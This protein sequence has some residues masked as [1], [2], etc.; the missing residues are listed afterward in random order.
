MK[1]PTRTRLPG[2]CLGSLIAALPPSACVLAD[3]DTHLRLNQSIEYRASQQERELLKDEVQPPSHLSTLT[4]DGQTYSVGDNLDDLGSALYLSIRHQQWPLVAHFLDAYVA[5]PGYDPMLAAYARGGLA[6]AAGDLGLAE[7][8]YRHLLALQD[9]FLPG[10]LELARVLFE[11]RKDRE[12]S[13]AFQHISARFDPSD[14]RAMG[15]SRSV[16]SFIEALD[17]REAWQGSIAI[18]PTWSDNLNLSSEDRQVFEFVTDEGILRLERKLPEAVSATGLD[19]EGTLNK[20]IALRGHHGLFIRSL[21][22]GQSY[23]DHKQYN[24]S[25]LISNVG[26]SYQNARNQYSLAPSFEFN[27]YGNAA[28]YGA[29]GI[30]GEWQHYL[31]PTRMLRLEGDYK[32]MKY[33]QEA[34][35]HND[36]DASSLYATLWQSLPRGWTLFGGLDITDRNSEDKANAYLQKG[37]RLGLAKEFESGFSAILFAAYRRRSHD[38]YSALLEARR[39]DDEQSYTFILNAQRLALY[40]ITPSLTLKYNKVASNVDWLYSHE[41]NSVSLKLE[42]QF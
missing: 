11:N 19:F 5:L 41:R 26:Y 18:G 30:R 1:R 37:V 33:R 40:G 22:Y 14:A 8:H 24:E 27:T 25:T 12:S 23:K 36:G 13:E 29:W 20:R 4:I 2:L 3:Q 42:R 35:A 28:M 16:D 6:R 10:Q 17:R 34:Y 21:V 39:E 7:G 32:E 15:V 38:I 31:S 9:D